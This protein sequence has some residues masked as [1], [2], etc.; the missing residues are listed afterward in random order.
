ML[1]I[2]RSSWTCEYGTKMHYV[3][4]QVKETDTEVFE[5]NAGLRVISFLIGDSIKNYPTK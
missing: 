1:L 3:G 4:N 5:A 2:I